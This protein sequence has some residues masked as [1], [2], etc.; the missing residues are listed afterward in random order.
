MFAELLARF[1]AYSLYLQQCH[2][3]SSG[4]LF[5]ADHLLFERLYNDVNDVIDAIAEKGIGATGEPSFVYLTDH[6]TRVADL[7]KEYPQQT[8]LTS[9]Y[10][11]AALQIEQDLYN[12]LV[13]AF[14]SE[15]HIGVQN[16]IQGLADAGTQRVYLVQERVAAIVPHPGK[17]KPEASEWI[18]AEN[19]PLEEDE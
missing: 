14:K 12:F 18:R 16:F 17:S 19:Y 8:D 4:A 10:F 13:S 1:R 3:A 7:V 2:W 11:V 6:L 9:D 5:Y 15:K